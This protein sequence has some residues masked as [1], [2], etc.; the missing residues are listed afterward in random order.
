VRACRLAGRYE[1]KSYELEK[2]QSTVEFVLV[3]P[4]CAL[5]L[6]AIVQ[7]GLLVRTSV[8][9]THSAREA[10][11]TAAIGGTDLDVRLAAV[12]AA[13]LDGSRLGVQVQRSG[14]SATVELRYVEHTDVALVG[15]L[16]GDAVFRVDATMLLEQ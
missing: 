9:V 13:D 16:V 7:V 6:L 14:N 5:M 15:T 4:F 10:V 11:R 3:L 1:L 12:T 2:G 8:L